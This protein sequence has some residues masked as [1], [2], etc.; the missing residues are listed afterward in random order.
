M[1]I[2]RRSFLGALS[3]F[4]SFGCQAVCPNPDETFDLIVVGSGVAGLTTAVI[5]AESG[6]RRVVVLE[7]QP[8][9]GGTSIICEGN[10]SISETIFQK[11]AGIIDSNDS[12]YEDMLIAG[13]RTKQTPELVRAMI[14]LDD[15]SLNGLLPAE[16][17][18]Q[19]SGSIPACVSLALTNLIP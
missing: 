9:L 11:Y 10:W 17:V 7:K 14:E 19:L 12:F 18:P 3:G 1:S 8:L 16:F 4:V 13:R 2:T 5:A 15:S 6:I